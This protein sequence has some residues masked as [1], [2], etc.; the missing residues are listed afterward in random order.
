MIVGNVSG[1]APCHVGKVEFVEG[2]AGFGVLELTPV[3]EEGLVA[4]HDHMALAIEVQVQL[5][6]LAA[7]HRFDGALGVGNL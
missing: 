5:I 7:R 3:L 2:V 4:D 6:I 1:S